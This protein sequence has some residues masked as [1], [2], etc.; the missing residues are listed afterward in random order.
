MVPKILKGRPCKERCAEEKA[1]G[2][3]VDQ[4]VLHGIGYG[5][6]W[7]WL[8]RCQCVIHL[9]LI[10]TELRCSG[11]NA[12]RTAVGAKFCRIPRREE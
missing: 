11:A 12:R 1:S 2:G 9:I 5:Q 6:A 7:L 10:V 4:G 3:E 8:Q